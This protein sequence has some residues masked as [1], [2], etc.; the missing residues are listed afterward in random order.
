MR[1]GNTLAVLAEASSESPTNHLEALELVWSEIHTHKKKSM[2]NY[3]N[4][5]RYNQNLVIYFLFI[6][7]GICLWTDLDLTWYA[8][9]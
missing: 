5:I 7:L 4:E 6:S 2:R 9:V 3:M 1:K 8:I